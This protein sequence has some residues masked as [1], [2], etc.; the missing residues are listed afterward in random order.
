ME[1]A[2]K[3]CNA[4][5]L[6]DILHILTTLDSTCVQKALCLA[7]DYNQLACVE[8]IVDPR[9]ILRV[10]RDPE[11][12]EAEFDLGFRKYGVAVALSSV[13]Q[14]ME[15]MDKLLQW[16]VR[17][18]LNLHADYEELRGTFMHFAAVEDNYKL[19]SVLYKSGMDPFVKDK[20][21]NTPMHEAVRM[22]NAEAVRALL[23]T[24]GMTHYKIDENH[25][26]HEVG[27]DNHGSIQCDF[28]NTLN[29]SSESPLNIAVS[30]EWRHVLQL[31]C[32]HGAD[33]NMYHDNYTALHRAIMGENS[34]CIQ[35]LLEN[36]ANACLRTRCDQRCTPLIMAV[37]LNHMPSVRMLLK[38]NCASDAFD[39]MN[40]LA[41]LHFSVI[42]DGG[43]EC[44]KQLLESGCDCNVRAQDGRTALMYSV[45][46]DRHDCLCRLLSTPGCN[47]NLVDHQWGMSALHRAADIG[48][49]LCTMQL[50][51]AGADPDIEDLDR[52]TALLLAINSINVTIVK[53]LLRWGCNTINHEN[54]TMAL[55]RN[56]TEIVQ[57]LV[58][59]TLDISPIRTYIPSRGFERLALKRASYCNW[60][61]EIASN[62]RSLRDLCRLVVRK[63][64]GWAFPNKVSLLPLPT[65]L[66]DFV[67]IPQL[68]HSAKV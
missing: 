13:C 21:G 43:I 26:S 37:Q 47:V 55:E 10:P 32:S 64:T 35:I 8:V 67:Q 11:E 66:K 9:H 30:M 4:D 62:P 6:E 61:N 20:K 40:G 41:A 3:N 60:L 57:A 7:L 19:L 52:V 39:A 29:N 28:L 18:G 38:R 54:L 36:G 25:F 51:D 24:C 56:Y 65:V 53:Y 12:M 16:A 59:A 63:A 2:V 46:Y 42:R 49:Y 15:Q 44:F 45:S 58:S 1:D 31:L 22:C 17:C 33:L 27:D 68:L 34:E 14:N 23:E 5:K 48:C 50:L